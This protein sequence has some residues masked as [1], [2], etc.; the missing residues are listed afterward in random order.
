MKELAWEL[1]ETSHAL[2]RFYD[3]RAAELGVTRAQWRV[4]AILGHNPGMKQVELADRLDVEPISA[5]RIIDRLEEAGLVERQRDPADRRAWRL[6]L[7]AT[8][9][10][11]RERLSDLA[12]QMSGEAFVGLGGD[13][14]ETMR[15]MLARIR[16]NIIAREEPRRVTA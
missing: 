14:I 4:I 12:E 7:T 6:S 9:E 1:A 5:C 8:A 10:P 13:Q 16:D 15:G 11:L 3:R 2:R